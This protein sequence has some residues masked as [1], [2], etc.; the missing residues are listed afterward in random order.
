VRH[1][2]GGGLMLG[3]ILFG[4]AGVTSGQASI[5]RGQQVF[6]AQKCATCHAV[7][8]KYDAHTGSVR[9]MNAW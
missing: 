6:A 9:I 4:A 1:V 8:A 3:V 7:A 2:L 5:A